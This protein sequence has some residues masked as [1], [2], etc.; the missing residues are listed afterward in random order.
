MIFNL[1]RSSL[2][3]KLEKEALKRQK[4][5]GKDS[6]EWVQLLDWPGCPLIDSEG[7][8]SC[9]RSLKWSD[10]V[11]PLDL[12]NFETQARRLRY[13]ALGDECRKNKIQHLLLA[14]HNDDQA[15]T[16]LLRLASG[17]KELGLQGMRSV[18]DIPE[19]WGVHG[20]HQSGQRD[21]AVLG[22]CREREKDPSSPHAQE[23]NRI[24][25]KDDIFE[26]GG[27][28]ILRPL[29]GFSKERLIQ[30]CRARSLAWEEDKTNKD[31][32]RTPRNNIREL[33]RSAKLPQA[34]QK[35]SM[36]H[37]AKQSSDKVHKQRT[38]AESILVCCEILLLDARCGGLIVRFPLNL[39]PRGEDPAPEKAWKAHLASFGFS[40]TL[41][42]QR[43]VE[44]VTPREEVSLQSL[45]QAV[46]SIFPELFE[47][48]R[49][50][51]PVSFTGGGAQFQRLYSP[52][53]APRSGLD[54]AISGKW[55]D[56]DPTFV[57]KLTRQPLSKAPLSHTVPPSAN[58]ES[59]IA[60]DLPSWS[61]WQLW[62][63]RYWIRLL[64]HSC[65][66]LIVRSF[67]LSDLNY[68]RSAFTPQRYKEFHRFLSLAAPDK[69]RWT[70][71]AVAELVD[72]TLPMGR[73]LA[74][75]TLGQ[76]GIFNIRD[77]NGKKKLAWQVRYKSVRLDSQ[78]SH[79]GYDKISRNRSLITSWEDSR[80]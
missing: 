9:V 51:Q 44:I 70:L 3:T 62:D 41:L 63:G 45:K 4:D 22:L 66:P 75:P 78:M 38:I 76:S 39:L 68:L 71:L 47:A 46:V 79:V 61:S 10:S 73:V 57:W 36:L 6:E 24:L 35:T 1:R 43:L 77:Q 28:K 8:H 25:A 26:N 69:V 12:P 18:A 11:S 54:P 64:N 21:L 5:S 59:S 72:N 80:P 29:L 14:H 37:L 52:L 7:L 48:D 20:V 49:R 2:I 30:T 67:Q 42:L 32:W 17:H 53:P 40:A 33:L 27:V 15:E 74:L 65:R 58:P 19:C 16:V 23:L 55:E 60:D 13:Q 34:L 50:L 31:T 56:L